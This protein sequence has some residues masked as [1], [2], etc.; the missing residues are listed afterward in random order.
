MVS[1]HGSIWKCKTGTDKIVEFKVSGDKIQ[2]IHIIPCWTH[3]I[4]N[5]KDTENLVTV[6]WVNEAIDLEHPD[7]FGEKA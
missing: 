6:I 5:L 1:S 7:M 3:N 2:T 4:I